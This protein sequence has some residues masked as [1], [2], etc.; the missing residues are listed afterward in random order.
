[1]QTVRGAQGVIRDSGAGQ[2]VDDW[3]E[4]VAFCRVLGILVRAAPSPWK[5]RSSL[6]K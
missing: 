2:K 3:E 5:F 6:E 1:M 4:M